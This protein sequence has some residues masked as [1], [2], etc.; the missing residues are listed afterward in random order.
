MSHRVEHRAREIFLQE[1]TD[2]YRRVDRMFVGLMLFQWVAVMLGAYWITPLTWVGTNSA[3]HLHLLAAVFFGGALSLFPMAL[4]WWLPGEPLTRY[5]IAIAQMLMSALLIHITGGRIETHFHVFGSLAFLG[6]YRD[7][8]VLVPATL[9]VAVD[10][11]LRGIFWPMSVYGVISAS[12]WR[13]FEHAGWVIFEDIFIAYSCLTMARQV[14]SLSRQ[15]AALEQA[16]QQTELI[17][18]ERTSAL[19]ASNQEL[20]TLNARLKENQAH[21]VQA[22]KLEAIGHLA[23]GI[24][25]EINT[26][27]QYIGDNTRFL[28]RS[29]QELLQVSKQEKTLSAAELD[30]LATEIPN[31]VDQSLEGIDR[32]AA[33]VRAMKEFSHPGRL[34]KTPSDLNHALDTTITVA[35]NEWKYAAEIITDFDPALP[36]VACVA[37]ELNQVFLNLI[38]NAAHAIIE[39]QGT[40]NPE[41]GTITIRTRTDGAWA[42]IRISDTG[43]GIP[44]TIRDQIFDPFFTTK[45]VGKG[46][47]QGLAIARSVIVDKHQGTLTFESEPGEGTTFIIRLPIV[48]TDAPHENPA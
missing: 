8:R 23:A 9:V 7:W 42:D 14:A 32:V 19:S 37:N 47:G 43:M 13:S 18:Q 41:K 4:V 45:A 1:M 44:H 20:I 34:E 36:L 15:T 28:Q 22:Q 6:F 27:I 5:V 31:A 11:L 35:R 21:L 48:D 39:M 24:A 12:I 29:F 26:P 46:T 40:D 38:V 2:N 17:V 33:I 30:Y 25:H 10:H 16:N 3:P